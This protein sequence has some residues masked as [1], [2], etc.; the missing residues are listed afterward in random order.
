MGEVPLYHMVEWMIHVR[1]RAHMGRT[2]YGQQVMKGALA[3][4]A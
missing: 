1:E 4:R 2:G 3:T